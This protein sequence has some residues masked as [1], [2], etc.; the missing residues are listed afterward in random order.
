[1]KH[2]IVIIDTGLDRMTGPRETN[3]VAV[4]MRPMWQAR[5]KDQG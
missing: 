3:D 5:K 1:M 2:E 4:T